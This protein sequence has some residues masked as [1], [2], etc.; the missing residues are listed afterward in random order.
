MAKKTMS[1]EHKAALAAGAKQSKAV[2]GYLKA[3]KDSGK[4]TKNRPEEDIA[5]DMEAAKAI[6]K[7]DSAGVLVQLMACK[8]EAALETELRAAQS[9]GDGSDWD[10]LTKDFVAQAAAYGERKGITWSV[11]RKMG[12]AGDVLVDAGVKRTRG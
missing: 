6:I 9:A 3:L 8:D 12:V 1:D 2:K 11:W 7:D 4:K 5:A 10:A